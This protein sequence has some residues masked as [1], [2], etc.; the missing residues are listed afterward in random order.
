MVSVLSLEVESYGAGE[1]YLTP[2]VC[3][4]PRDHLWDGF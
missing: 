3:S 1:S 2:L 4:I